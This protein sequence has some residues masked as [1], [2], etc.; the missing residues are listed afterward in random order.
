M[1]YCEVLTQS[2]RNYALTRDK[3]WE[4][5][6]RAIEPL[7]DVLIKESINLC[8]K[9]DKK[10][11]E[12]LDK[13]NIAL[14]K[15]EYKAIELVNSGKADEAVQ[16]LESTEY[17]DQKQILSGGLSNYVESKGLAGDESIVLTPSFQMILELE[18][19]LAISEAA[20]KNEKMAAIGELICHKSILLKLCQRV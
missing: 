2:A 8:K 12:T 13:A 15:M 17:N 9:E 1:R 11:I 5:R 19:K 10:F 18:K 3:K 6:Y 14:V 16:L 20:F 4:K 7:L